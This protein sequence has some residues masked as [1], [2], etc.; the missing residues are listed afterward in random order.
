M[1]AVD[2][3]NLENICTKCLSELDAVSI[4]HAH[5]A[6]EEFEARVELEK[7]K[8]RDNKSLWSFIPFKINIE[9]R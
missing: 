5:V 3:T 9:W 2:N 4:A 6:R 1:Q 8:I 7:Q